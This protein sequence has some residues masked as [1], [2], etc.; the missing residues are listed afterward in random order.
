[1]TSPAVPVTASAASYLGAQNRQAVEEV[2]MKATR[3]PTL[4]QGLLYLL[5]AIVR[6]DDSCD[7][8]PVLETIRRAREI[9]QDTLRRDTDIDLE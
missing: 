5:K 7:N 6:G 4:T 8:G 2:F 3:I 9:A 1:V